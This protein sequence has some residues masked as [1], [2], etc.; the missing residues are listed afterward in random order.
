MTGSV[1]EMRDAVLQAPGSISRK[2]RQTSSGVSPQQAYSLE[3]V[4]NPYYT[5]SIGDSDYFGYAVGSGTF[6]PGQ[7]HYIGGA[8]RGA[9]SRGKVGVN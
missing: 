9:E 3:F 5:S 4:P 7:E 8:P 2:R 6:V 1:V